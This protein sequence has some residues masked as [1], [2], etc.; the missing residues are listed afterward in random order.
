MLFADMEFTTKLESVITDA[1]T[2][3]DDVQQQCLLAIANKFVAVSVPPLFVRKAREFVTG[4]D[5]RVATMVGF[6]Y[7]YSAV[8]AKL[9]EVLLSIVDG[10]DEIK[11]MI[12]ITA[13][14]NNDWQ[15]VGK[16]INGIRQ[17][18][19]SQNKSLRVC[20]EAGMLTREEIIKCCDIYG[21]AG[22]DALITSSGFSE[23]TIA[24]DIAF[25]RSCLN[26][27]VSLHAY[28]DGSFK[29]AKT[30]LEEGA[31]RL[32]SRNVV[33]LLHEYASLN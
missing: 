8:E 25:I 33:T 17:V 16:E 21:L 30:F 26:D 28:C 2:T 22:V 14:K 5:V 11:L 18:T 24:E 10:A 1:V 12:N 27:S 9:A 23:H 15:C 31:G 4:T 32:L 19:R 3:V 6:P 20:I 29:Q 13:I 7:G